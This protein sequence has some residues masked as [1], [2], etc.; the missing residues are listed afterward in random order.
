[1]L[2]MVRSRLKILKT[3]DEFEAQGTCPIDAA[4]TFRQEMDILGRCAH[5]KIIALIECNFQHEGRDA[6]VLGS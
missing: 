3:V 4:A 1:M 5:P 6:M 2:L